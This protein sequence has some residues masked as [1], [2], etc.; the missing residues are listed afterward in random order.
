MESDL[1]LDIKIGSLNDELNKKSKDKSDYLKILEQLNQNALEGLKKLKNTY[2]D[3]KNDLVSDCL[4]LYLH[5]L[6]SKDI[7]FIKSKYDHINITS[8]KTY[9]EFL[10]CWSYEN[11]EVIEKLYGEIISNPFSSNG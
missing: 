4:D 11:L 6:S 10:N 8:K 2:A 1:P 9:E 3:S 7:S 5:L